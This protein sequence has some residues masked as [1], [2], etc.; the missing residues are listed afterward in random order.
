MFRFLCYPLLLII[1]S[2]ARAGELPLFDAHIHYNRDA[3]STVSP[4]AAIAEL[5]KAGVIRALVSSSSDEGT[6]K[7]YAQAPDLVFP[8]LR[9]YRT[10]VEQDTWI[11]DESVIAYLKERLEKY[12]YVAIGEF[13]VD[14]A[15]A[16]LPVVRRLVQLAKQYRLLLF[17]HAD[18]DAVKR[19]FRQDPDA[20]ILWAH[21]GFEEPQQ[22]GEMMRRY[23]RLWAELSIRSDVTNNGK[24][25]GD[26]RAVLLAFP[27]RF[28]VG[29][30][31][32]MPMHWETVADHAAW[33]RRWLADLPTDVA[34]R[35]AYRNGK[36]LLTAR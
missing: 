29:T 28:M 1:A 31:T 3:W 35:I 27:D 15:D 7:L 9:P 12:K 4:Q 16:D 6:Q 22:V 17:A 2:F 23:P 8:S 33:T 21:A 30:D 10:M 18:A 36:A 19:L 25:A 11:H 5:R 24:I 32:Y 13:H 20:R 26:W 14:G 34:E